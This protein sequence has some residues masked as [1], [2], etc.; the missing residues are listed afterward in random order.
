MQARRRSPSQPRDLAPPTVQLELCPQ[1]DAAA[2]SQAHSALRAQ[3]QPMLDSIA[4]RLGLAMPSL[5]ITTRTDL[6]EHSFVLR[7]R[8]ASL[9]RGRA[10]SLE[11]LAQLLDAE[12]SNLVARR[13]RELLSLEELQQLLDRTAQWAPSLV[14]SV[15]PRLFTLTQLAELLRR[16]LDEG[17]SIAPLD[18]ILESLATLSPK[19]AT[20]ERGLDLARRALRDQLVEA[21]L[22]DDTLHVHVL[23]PMIE[24]ALR[25]AAQLI[26][27]ER[28]LA[29]PPELAQD[30]VRAVRLARAAD[31]RAPVLVTQADVRRSLYEVLKEDVP[32][33][34]GLAYTELPSNV[35]LEQRPPIQV[36]G[37]AR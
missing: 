37:S 13:T 5:S 6:P 21:H 17:V 26:E 32:E 2:G 24:D 8:H 23:D 30:I 28:V 10:A 22:H 35:A 1:L 9:L 16:L 36:G 31:A 3:I 25:D 18:R 34:L 11:E 20:L 15:V 14:Q 33:A 7:L 4:T 19:A 12:L 29:L 27:G